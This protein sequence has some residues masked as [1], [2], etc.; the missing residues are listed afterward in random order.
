MWIGCNDGLY[1]Y[2]GI[3]FR[4]FTHPEQSGRSIS[5]IR[6]DSRGRIWCQN[7]A[8]QIFCIENGVMTVA[9]DASARF[10]T[11]PV[12]DI[13][14]AGNLYIGGQNEI[15]VY[16]TDKKLRTAKLPGNSK[17]IITAIGCQADGSVIAVSDKIYQYRKG[18][19]NILTKTND[20]EVF[21]KI[22]GRRGNFEYMGDRLLFFCEILQSK[23]YCLAEIKGDSVLISPQLPKSLAG[24]RLYN[25]NA[26]SPDELWLNT[27][28]GTYCLDAGLQSKYG[29]AFFSG[30]NVSD[31]IKDNEG[32]YWVATLE[33]GIQIV[34]AMDIMQYT[35]TNSSLLDNNTTSIYLDN[36]KLYIGYFNGEVSALAG[37]RNTPEFFT[38][39]KR[40]NSSE[41]ID[42]SPDGSFIIFSHNYLTIK[43]RGT[44]KN[45]NLDSLYNIRDFTFMPDGSILYAN[46]HS[47]GRL[48]LKKDNSVRVSPL[49]KMS[50]RCVAYDDRFKRKWVGFNDGV[51][52]FDAQDRQ[53]QF[54]PSGKK[55]F[56][57]CMKYSQ[58]VL[59]IGTIADGLLGVVGDSV[60]H[61]FTDAGQLSGKNVRVII[62]DGST[63]WVATE[64]GINVIDVL[65]GSNT[66]IDK[67]DGFPA[68]EINDIVLDGDTVIV[69]STGGLFKFPKSIKKQNTRRPDIFISK[70]LINGRELDDANALNLDYDQNKLTVYFHT[71]G[72]GEK[73]AYTYYYQLKGYDSTWQLTGRNTNHISYS[74][75]PPG[76]YTFSIKTVNEDGYESVAPATF[77]IE[78]GKPVWQRWWFY[79]LIVL[80]SGALV[81][82]IFINRIRAIQNRARLGQ[83]IRSSQLTALKAQMNPHFVFNALNSIQDL[84]LKNDVRA[85]NIYLGRFSEL[86]RKVLNASDKDSIAL[87]EEIDILRL[88]LELE[89]LRFGDAFTYRIDI[90]TEIDT[91]GISIPSMI[92]QPFIE[93]AI[94]HGLLHKQGNKNVE[95]RFVLDGEYIVCT[96]TDNGVGRKTSADI[97]LRSK[98]PHQ[99]FAIQATKKRLDLLNDY[100]KE[101]IGVTITDMEE[102]GIATGTMVRL[103]L[104]YDILDS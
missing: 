46:S 62:S 84:M 14:K 79:L 51:Y 61:K 63:L 21:N 76:E 28:N 29:K 68:T 86:M 103:V 36:D 48:S 87:Q 80:V 19:V 12:F 85:S 91:T 24:G 49:R 7:F 33:S 18:S 83:L 8:G 90:G 38:I 26:I 99:G 4:Q 16:G 11:Y 27:R 13:D 93:N 74:S 15:L 53:T 102:A 70:I 89:K 56:A 25:I 47:A 32:N 88:Y 50:S 97:K 69:A 23:E 52:F 44:L 37:G 72:L 35:K 81:S 66:C 3:T 30:N 22:S 20:S 6:E 54:L 71:S 78:I 1:K 55:V 43:R 59:W 94:K 2:D 65:H 40:Y 57:S 77:N 100:H 73:N 101:K 60:V 82:F 67:Y 45:Y 39:D 98:R 10:S 104:P 31:I 95:V 17:S 34:P 96:I 58:G 42:K 92:I 75:L 9:F 64:K 5:F 41:K